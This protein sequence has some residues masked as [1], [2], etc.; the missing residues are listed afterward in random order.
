MMVMIVVMVMVVVVIM[1]VIMVM[2]VVV[3][4][5]VVM[6]MIVLVLMI[7]FMIVVVVGQFLAAV[8]GH[9]DVG[10]GDAELFGGPAL[11]ADAGDA[12]AVHPFDEG[13]GIGDE[14]A[15]RGH[16]HIPGGAHIAFEVE[17]FHASIPFIWLIRLARKPAPKPLSM[18]TTLTPL[19]QELSMDS[20]A[21][22][23]PKLAP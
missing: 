7:M 23:P 4:M 18:L 14:F 22:R 12:E 20:S 10:A 6:V 13:V 17:D 19:A 1:V 16:Q 11:Q 21:D 3:V 15:E 9:G 2:V 5:I 8:H